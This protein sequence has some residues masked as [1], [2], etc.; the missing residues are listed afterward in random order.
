VNSV[1]PGAMNTRML[2]ET[3][4]AGPAGIRR[5]YGQAVD[6]KQKG[7]VPP[8][9][10]AELVVF[11]ASPESDG[12]TGRLIAAIWDDWRSLPTQREELAK[13]DIYTLRRVVPK[14]RGMGW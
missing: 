14:D 4:A 2:E 1:S 12:V 10:A 7:G 9:K 8:E 13:T 3:L 11:L 5:E 6:R